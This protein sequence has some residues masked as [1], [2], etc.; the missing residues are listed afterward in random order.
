MR[1]GRGAA[2][3]QSYEIFGKAGWVARWSPIDEGSV[4]GGLS[5]VW[6]HGGGFVENGPNNS[7]PATIQPGTDA[8]NVA[9]VGAQ[10]THLFVPSF[11][12]QMNIALAQSFASQGGVSGSVLG[13]NNISANFSEQAWAEYG[14]RLGYRVADGL[15]ADVFG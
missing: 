10:W 2:S 8:I 15:V 3:A 6:Q 1:Q 9:R 14:V 5:R 11:E 7:S 4:Y 12:T 13:Y